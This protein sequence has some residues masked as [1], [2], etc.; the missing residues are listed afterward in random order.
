MDH[1]DKRFMRTLAI[2]FMIGMS[3]ILLLSLVHSSGHE[4]QVMTDW[5]WWLN[6]LDG[7]P[8][9]NDGVWPG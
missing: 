2:I 5:I 4:P 9:N 6:H 3:M 8:P 7:R 1:Q